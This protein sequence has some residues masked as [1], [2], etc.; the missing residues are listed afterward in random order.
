M[1]QIR[2][3]F[4]IY[5]D[6]QNYLSSELLKP[7]RSFRQTSGLIY[8]Q[9]QKSYKKTEFKFFFFLNFRFSFI[10]HFLCENKRSNKREV[11]HFLYF[12]IFLANGGVVAVRNQ[13]SGLCQEMIAW[14]K[15]RGKQS[16]TCPLTMAML[17]IGQRYAPPIVCKWSL[18]VLNEF[19]KYSSNPQEVLSARVVPK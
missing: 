7:L 11:F 15:S 13:S 2:E 8:G 19:T 17:P 10:P 9:S 14:T 16:A 5:I 18:S 3:I 12:L 4:S 1:G 6:Y